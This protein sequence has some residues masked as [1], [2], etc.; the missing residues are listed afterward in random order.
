MKA[1]APIPPAR[2]A[3]AIAS[4]RFR[5]PRIRAELL[6]WYESCQRPLPWRE[7][8]DPYAILVSEVMLQQ[9]QVERVIRKYVEF[10]ER[11]PTFEALAR[12]PRDEV[13]RSWHPL[14]YN[15]RAVRLHQLAKVVVGKPDGRLPAEVGELA[16][17]PG[18]GPYTARAVACFAFD[19]QLAL[20]ETNVRRVLA[21]VLADHFGFETP[22]KTALEHAVGEALPPGRAADWNQA[23]MDLGAT[24]CA[25][26]RP[27]CHSCPLATEC[28]GAPQRE[29]TGG[30]WAGNRPRLRGVDVRKVAEHHAAYRTPERFAGSRRFFR[31]RIVQHLGQL[32]PGA[33]LTV[34]ELGAALQTSSGPTDPGWLLELLRSLEADGLVGLSFE[35]CEAGVTE[36]GS[37]QVRLAR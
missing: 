28:A 21:R 6:E 30:Y 12:A 13:I 15:R 35:G 32:S 17:L 36:S 7:T 22:T 33:S 23:L 27:L 19:Q 24:I 26:K 3:P 20:I 14:G 2:A 16:Q 18:V 1:E 9:T 29:G 11:F 25:P 5:L 8:H 10:L 4:W 31:G 34:D 37:L